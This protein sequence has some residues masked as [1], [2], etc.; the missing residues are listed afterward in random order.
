MISCL[1]ITG[2]PGTGKTTVALAL[3]ARMMKQGSAA[4]AL[5]TDLLKVTLRSL[6]PGEFKGPAYAGDF[7]EAINRL[8]PLLEAQVAKAAQDGYLLIVEGTLAL[9]FSPAGGLKVLLELEHSERRRRIARKHP[10][11]QAALARS[12]LER[13]QKA[14]AASI[15]PDT[16]RLDA[17]L[18]LPLILDQIET[19]LRSP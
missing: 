5:H 13:Y 16:L 17:T 4:L 8:R 1:V 7:V 18:P 12:S 2:M 15:A 9:G 6:F 14:L 19:R 11:A 3:A 10:V